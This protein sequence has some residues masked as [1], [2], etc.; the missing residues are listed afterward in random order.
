M[1][2]ATPMKIIKIND[3]KA[4]VESSG[5]NHTVSV[6]LIKNAKVGEYVLVHGEM[7]INKVP[8]KDAKKILQIINDKK[9]KK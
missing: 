3:K 6:D 4:V 7:A 2:L 9:D 1:C 8:S 5:H